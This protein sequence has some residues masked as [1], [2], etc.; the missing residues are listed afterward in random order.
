[1]TAMLRV[2]ASVFGTAVQ[3]AA[4]SLHRRSVK[5]CNRCTCLC[6]SQ[7]LLLLPPPNS[8]LLSNGR[9]QLSG[10]TSP[11]L[12]LLLLLLSWPYL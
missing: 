2:L 4:S 5:L 6:C 10:C 11:L 9:I 7:L 12:A 1:M 8:V 3:C